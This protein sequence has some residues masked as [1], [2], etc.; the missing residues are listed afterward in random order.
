M[1]SSHSTRRENARRSLSP[2]FSLHCKTIAHYTPRKILRILRGDPGYL[3]VVR[4]TAIFERQ[5]RKSPF[6][7]RERT[8]SYVTAFLPHRKYFR[9]GPL[10]EKGFDAVSRQYTPQNI[11]FA[12]TPD[13]AVENAVIR[14]RCKEKASF[15]RGA[16][17]VVRNPA[18]LPHR[19]FFRR[20]PRFIPHEKSCGFY[21]GTPVLLII[22]CKNRDFWMKCAKAP[23]FRTRSVLGVRKRSE[24]GG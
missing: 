10:C 2:R 5:I 20:G 17:L 18:V 13:S 8:K 14:M 7:K 4:K 9:R 6:R 15:S 22:V 16:Y 11:R 1:P 23:I 12:G 19:K 3:T 21:A 24:Y